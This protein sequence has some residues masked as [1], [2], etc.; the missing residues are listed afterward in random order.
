MINKQNK[1]NYKLLLFDKKINI[2]QSGKNNFLFETTTLHYFT[3]TDKNDKQL[4]TKN[5][6]DC[7]NSFLIRMLISTLSFSNIVFLFFDE[8]FFVCLACLKLKVM[9]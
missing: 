7:I 8:H 6:Y 1:N 4:N 2:L 9:V 5:L 3:M